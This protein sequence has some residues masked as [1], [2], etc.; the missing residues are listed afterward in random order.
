MIYLFSKQVYQRL[1]FLLYKDYVIDSQ[2][3][4]YYFVWELD[5]MIKDK[6]LLK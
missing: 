1:V 3:E 4:P 2:I 6:N 5:Y